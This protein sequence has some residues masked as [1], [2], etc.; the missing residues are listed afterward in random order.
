MAVSSCTASEKHPRLSHHFKQSHAQASS[1]MASHCCSHR[2]HSPTLR[3]LGSKEHVEAAPVGP[4]KL[5]VE[6]M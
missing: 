6:S 1:V 2:P 4:P 5:A 3:D